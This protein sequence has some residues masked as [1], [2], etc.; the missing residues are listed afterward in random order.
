[1]NVCVL[2]LGRIGLT[3]SLALSSKNTVFGIDT[4]KETI[5]TLS[6]GKSTF[7]ESNLKE[8]LKK[9]IGENFFVYEK[10][11]NKEID[12]F[13]ICVGTPINERKE[14]IMDHIKNASETIGQ[15]LKTNQILFQFRRELLHFF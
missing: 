7:H 2:G 3:L 1:M 13:V 4:N 10:I 14:P 9:F 5:R 15:N 6:S 8:N 12:V 11:P